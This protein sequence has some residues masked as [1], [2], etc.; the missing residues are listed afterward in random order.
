[1]FL[2]QVN[3]ID[4]D[5]KKDLG[6]GNRMEA[7][8]RHI[9]VEFYEC[10]AEKIHDV[11]HIEQ[12]MIHAAE[13]AGATIINSTFH[14][15]SPFGVSGVI[16]IEESHLAIHTWPEY[17]FASLDLFTCGDSIDPWVAFD[18]L[19]QE[20]GADHSSSIELQRGQPHL[21]E[22]IALDTPV[23]RDT[24]SKMKR[25]VKYNRNIWFTE[26]DNNIALS[27]R[28]KGDPLYR[29]QSKYQRVEIIDTIAYGKALILDGMVMTTE[30]DEYVYHEMIAHVPLLTHPHPEKV[31]IIGGGDGGGAR[32]ALKHDSVKQV[33]L[34]EID[35]LVIEACKQYLPNLS[36]SFD[37]PNLNLY[38]ED[39]IEFVKNCPEKTYDVIIIDST[40]PVGPAEGL[41]TSEFYK[42]VY[43]CLK[44]DGI[45]VAQSESPHFNTTVFQEI[46]HCYGNI[47]G[48]NNVHPY[49]VYIPTY[50]SG[51]WSFSFCSKNHLHPVNDLDM[52]RPRQFTSEHHLK[53]YNPEIHTSAFMLPTF[54]KNLLN[55]KK[56]I[57][58]NE[59]TTSA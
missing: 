23:V 35:E 5:Q 14:H 56:D 4:K 50:P 43:R 49:L 3:L 11:H 12:S 55:Q 26:R 40:D 37:H 8:G 58:V 9:I 2:L 17:R 30:Q 29:Q 54:V 6:R 42:D 24:A 32:E 59:Q 36:N 52:N 31:L 20:F 53:Y 27:L 45:M 28:H 22:H 21:L 39:G 34:V 1:M 57:T 13:I 19:K 41:F 44:D 48:Y 47:F 10:S 46:Y 7:L 15:F 25:P 16:V 51:M 38:V 33:D 18:Y